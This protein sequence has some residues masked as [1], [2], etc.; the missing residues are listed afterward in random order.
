MV[1]KDLLNVSKNYHKIFFCDPDLF[2]V[3]SVIMMQIVMVPEYVTVHIV[4]F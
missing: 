2:G 1:Y 4:R 3:C